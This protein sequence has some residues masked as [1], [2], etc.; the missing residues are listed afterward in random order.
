MVSGLTIETTAF[1]LS[2]PQN[3]TTVS[4]VLSA[5]TTTRSPRATPRRDQRVRESVRARVELGIGEPLLLADERDL[6]REPARR[7]DQVVVE[8]GD[9]VGHGVSERSVDEGSK[10]DRRGRRGGAEHVA[11]EELRRQDADQRH[12]VGV[13]ELRRSSLRSLSFCQS[14][15]TAGRIEDARLGD[16][17]LA[18]RRLDVIGDAVADERERVGRAIRLLLCAR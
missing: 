13:R 4:T 10:L 12:V 15:S 17:A 1:A 18:E 5:K 11:V 6:V 2:T 9:G 7:V 14:C 3:E 8:Q 16:R